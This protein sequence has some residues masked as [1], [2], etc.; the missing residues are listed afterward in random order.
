MNKN[1]TY[2]Q[3]V[4]FLFLCIVGTLLHF[5]FPWSGGSWLAA[6]FAPVNESVWEHLK[7]LVFPLT[8][9]A[10]AQSLWSGMNP[11]QVWAAKS[12]GLLVGLILIPTLYYLVSGGLGRSPE[13]FNI[14]LFFLT[15]AA[16]C[17]VEQQALIREETGPGGVLTIAV[18]V[19]LFWVLTFF[20]PRIPLFQDPIT[21]TWGY[22]S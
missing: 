16:V 2:W 17:R 6:L 4:C 20:P 10:L 19:C 3:T 11:R 9:F 5:L 14:A 12:R 18:I 15:A 1:I 8:A 22:F 7:L 21:G 13:W